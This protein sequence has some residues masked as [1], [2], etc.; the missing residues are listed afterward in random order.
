MKSASSWRVICATR[1]FRW[2][3]G[4]VTAT[5]CCGSVTPEETFGWLL[6][7]GRAWR[8]LEVRLRRTSK[9]NPPH[10]GTSEV[11]RF[12]RKR[13]VCRHGPPQRLVRRRRGPLGDRSLSRK[14]SDYILGS[15]H[16]ISLT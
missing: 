5:R 16:K 8:V 12:L 4:E 6:E 14:S 15:C 13:H 9:K 1:C 2:E 3:M 10:P 11:G 7:L